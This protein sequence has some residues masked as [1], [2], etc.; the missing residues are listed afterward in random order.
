M[1]S[2]PARHAVDGGLFERPAA[3]PR[4]RGLRLLREAAAFEWTRVEPAIFGALLEG[5]LGPER[6]WALGAHYTSRPTF[7]SASCRPSSSP[8]E[9]E[10]IFLETLPEVE[11][12][13]QDFSGRRAR[14]RVR[15][16][17]LPH[18]AYRNLRRLEASL[19]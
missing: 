14:S 17:E 6:Q 2:T 11:A 9:N 3:L 1:G 12:A 13:E 16:G 10:S 4:G 15:L 19:R 7:S 8:G 5:T 18:V